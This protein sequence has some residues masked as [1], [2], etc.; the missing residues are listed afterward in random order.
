MDQHSFLNNAS[1]QYLEQMYVKY[2]NDP[3]SVEESWR[4]FFAGLE[5]SNTEFGS[6]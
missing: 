4:Y 2:K 3:D 6:V 1:P 5:F